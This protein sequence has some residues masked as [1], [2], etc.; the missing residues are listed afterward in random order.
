VLSGQGGP[1][2]LHEPDLTEVERAHVNQ[3]LDEG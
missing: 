3:A 2:A 1:Y